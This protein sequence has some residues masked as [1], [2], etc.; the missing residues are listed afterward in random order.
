MSPYF[1]LQNNEEQCSLPWEARLHRLAPTLWPSSEQPNWLSLHPVP[2]GP[3][4]GLHKRRTLFL[5]HL[6]TKLNV[7]PL[8]S[9]RKLGGHELR[10]ELH[11]IFAEKFPGAFE[12]WWIIYCHNLLIPKLEER[13]PS[14]STQHLEGTDIVGTHVRQ[15]Q[16]RT[17]SIPSCA[18]NLQEFLQE[19]SLIAST[20]EVVSNWLLPLSMQTTGH[21]K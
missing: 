19:A 12:V 16:Q 18:K 5:S 11:I 17:S 1:L 2:Q 3:D 8:C 9:D 6:Y 20:Y 15:W 13:L 4:V 21:E 14:V 7:F 10:L